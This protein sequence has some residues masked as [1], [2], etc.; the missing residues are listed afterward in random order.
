M[1]LSKSALRLLA[2]E[3]RHKPF[4]SRVLL[5]GRQNV[6]ARFDE[7]V[8]ILRE[9][10]IAPRALAR[11]TKTTTNIPAWIGT[12][13]EQNLSDAAFLSLLGC[14]EVLALDRS[15]FEGAELV[16]DLNLRAPSD[17]ENRFDVIIDGGTLEHVF[18]V[19]QALANLVLMTRI[20]GR[21]IH[22]SPASNY[23]NHGFYQFSP[24]LFFDYYAANGFGDFHASFA[25][26]N[27]YL[28]HKRRWRIGE[29]NR[30]DRVTSRK[31]LLTYFVATKTQMSIGDAI[32]TQTFYSPEAKGVSGKSSPRS[33]LKRIAGV[34]S[35]DTK[36]EI[37]GMFPWLDP[38]R[39]R[40]WRRSRRI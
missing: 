13:D 16:W 8:E 31:A 2:E 40:W 29:T 26:H 7:A 36:L 4:G 11:E 28:S 12:P 18:D 34:L 1:G 6:Y 35:E 21:V 30:L 19:R 23:A 25:E 14:D 33:V 24:T 38:A 5:L 15:S 10:G 20:G 3:H 39:L 37:L 22:M 27:I 32:P 9:L 17:L